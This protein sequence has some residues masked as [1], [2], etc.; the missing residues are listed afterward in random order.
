MWALKKR[1]DLGMCSRTLAIGRSELPV[2][3][4]DRA[5]SEDRSGGVEGMGVQVASFGHRV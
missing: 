5:L 4:R 2:T 3:K 1:E